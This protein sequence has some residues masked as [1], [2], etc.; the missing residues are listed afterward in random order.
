MKPYVFLDRDGTVIM[1]RNYLS[2]P[3]QVVLLPGAAKGLRH[4][5]ELGFGLVLVTNQSGIGRGYFSEKDVERVH[6]RL[7]ELLERE[8]V[9][10]D[11]VYYCPHH[12]N[13][14]CGCRKPASGMIDVARSCFDVDMKRSV[15]VGDKPCDILLGKNCELRTILVRT[16]HGARHEQNGDCSP[17]FTADDLIAAAAWISKMLYR[18]T[19]RDSHP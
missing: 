3:A 18:K 10:L 1:E 14:G 19:E 17:T 2:D 13:A 16:G 8:K 9:E 15:M 7:A 5:R 6:A 4:L 11:A 12:P